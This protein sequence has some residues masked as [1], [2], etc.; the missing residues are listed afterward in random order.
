MNTY[1]KSKKNLGKPGLYGMYVIGISVVRIK[2]LK[3][4]SQPYKA[5]TY[6]RQTTAKQE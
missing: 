6:Y 2:D 1:E 3:N 4:I 5:A